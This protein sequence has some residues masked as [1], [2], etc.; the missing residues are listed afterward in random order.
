[1]GQMKYSIM[2]YVALLTIGFDDVLRWCLAEVL[3]D[4]LF[5][6]CGERCIKT[7]RPSFP[8]TSS[9]I[10]AC[11]DQHVSVTN[12]ETVNNDSNGT[13]G[14]H[15]FYNCSVRLLYHLSQAMIVGSLVQTYFSLQATS[16]SV[17]AAANIFA[18]ALTRY[19]VSA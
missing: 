4:H 17:E 8:Y 15:R 1:M 2:T 12:G 13:L 6:S 11:I 3:F 14:D 7:I 19:S 9:S 10:G 5:S 16:S 18:G